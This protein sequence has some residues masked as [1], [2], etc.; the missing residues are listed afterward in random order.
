[1]AIEF[2]LRDVVHRITAKFFPA[3]L[4]KAKKPYILR[5]VYQPELDIHGVASKAEA[6][7]FTTPAK[8]IEEGL[9]VGLELIT[10]LAADGYKIKTP[11]FTLKVSIPGEYDGAETHLPAGTHPQGRLNLSPELRKYLSE[12]VELQFDGVENANGMIAE[13]I[14]LYTS[15]ADISLKPLSLFEVRGAGLKI[16]ADAEHADDTGIFFESVVDGHRLR[17]NPKDMAV[18]NPSTLKAIVSHS[19]GD[20][21]PGSEWYVVVRT[22]AS[23]KGSHLLKNVREVKSDFALVIAE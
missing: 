18:N 4:P 5:A 12:H 13:V 21:P 19:T 1:M 3:F 20:L 9:T 6:Y 14:N 10:Y 17:N 23:T 8:V 15:E 11:V 22:Q 7:N 16:D 2:N